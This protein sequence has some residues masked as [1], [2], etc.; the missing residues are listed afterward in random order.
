M[1][2]AYFNPHLW[3]EQLPIELELV[4]MCVMAKY[5]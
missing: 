3:C 4:V 2:Y 1:K 5:S